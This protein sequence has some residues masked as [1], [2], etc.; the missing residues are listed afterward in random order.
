MKTLI[1]FIMLAFCFVGC[2][3]G[4]KKIPD[5]PEKDREPKM[6]NEP[7]RVPPLPT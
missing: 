5:V 2:D 1:L 6:H 7:N 4:K 3:G